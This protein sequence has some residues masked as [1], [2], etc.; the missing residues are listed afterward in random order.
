MPSATSP[1]GQPK[2]TCHGW[3]VMG[4]AGTFPK[5]S[6]A[7]PLYRLRVIKKV[8]SSRPGLVG[9]SKLAL[10]RTDGMSGDSVGTRQ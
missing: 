5:P 4:L 7:L 1:L 9:P 3:V 2:K 6:I 10:R 8:V